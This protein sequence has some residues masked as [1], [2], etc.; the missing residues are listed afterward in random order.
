MR[1]KE[2]YA[3]VLGIRSP[4]KVADV[5]LPVGKGEV[6]FLLRRRLE[7]C[8]RWPRKAVPKSYILT[9]A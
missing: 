3:S 7:R 8:R 2:L 6:K 9:A 5:E 4:W 1:D